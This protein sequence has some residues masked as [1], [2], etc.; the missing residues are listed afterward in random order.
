[1]DADCGSIHGRFQPFHRG[2]LEYALEAFQR[3]GHL[4]IGIT[5]HNIEA[6]RW[7]A[8][9]VAKHRSE[10]SSNPFTYSDRMKIIESSLV[11]EN[12]DRSRFSIIPFPIETP[13][14]LDQYLRKDVV[15]FTT[16]Y[17]EWNRSKIE[18]LKQHGY[19]VVTLWEREE[20]IFEGKTIRQLIAKGDRRWEA[21]VPVGAVDPINQ[22]W[23]RTNRS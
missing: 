1:M 16:V 6:L 15:I 23:A 4:F 3:C 18:I 2:H 8:L 22:F 12:I 14:E 13:T 20:K 21:M 11:G 5:Q 10:P 9:D 17:D 7:S 19:V